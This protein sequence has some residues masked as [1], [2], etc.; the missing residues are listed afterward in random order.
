[1]LIPS[2]LGNIASRPLK[3]YRT[4]VVPIACALIGCGLLFYIAGLDSFLASFSNSTMMMRVFISVLIIAPPSF[5]MGMPYPNGLDNLQET[6]PNLLPWAWG[7]N[8]GLSLV[9]S[10][11]ARLVSV[12]SGFPVLLKLGIGVYLLVGLLFPIN[13][14]MTQD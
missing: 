12:A 3:Q 11:L 2:A 9:G 1:M 6:K 8:G 13:Q 14:K 4:F 10:A 5:F 7:M